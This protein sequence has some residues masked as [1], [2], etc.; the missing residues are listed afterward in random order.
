MSHHRHSTDLTLQAPRFPR[1]HHPGGSKK[2]KQKK[3]YSFFKVITDM[4]TS[5]NLI[6]K[7]HVTRH[8]LPPSTLPSLF[9]GPWCNKS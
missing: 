7:E 9:N 4:K 2:Q 3:T 5:P 8:H 1:T 6:S